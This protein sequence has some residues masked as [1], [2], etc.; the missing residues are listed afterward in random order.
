L[1]TCTDCGRSF[2][3]TNQCHARQ[4]TTV[5]EHLA[6]LAIAIFDK[7]VGVLG[8]AGELRIHRQK[9]RI[10]FIS[11]M[12]FGGMSPAGERVDLDGT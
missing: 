1:S 6:E 9:T 8:S 12:A 11:T 10:A 2:A 4:D 3:T 5:D 7:V